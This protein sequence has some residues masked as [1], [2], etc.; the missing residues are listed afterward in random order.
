MKVRGIR[1]GISVENNSKGAILSATKKILK[2]MVKANSV[3]VDDICSVIFTVTDDLNATFPAVAAR[4]M[5]WRYVPML[6]L[7]E[8]SVPDGARGILRVLMHVNTTKSMKEIKHIYLKRAANLRP[9][10]ANEE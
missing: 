9:D 1:G 4:E 10:L 3:E 6:C 8:M 2:E 7:T 5:G